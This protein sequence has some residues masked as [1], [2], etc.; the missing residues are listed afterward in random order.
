MTNYFTK[1]IQVIFK[2]GFKG[3]IAY[4]VSGPEFTLGLPRTLLFFMEIMSDKLILDLKKSILLV[5]IFVI[6]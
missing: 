1:R 5:F 6:F 4:L 2:W 3:I